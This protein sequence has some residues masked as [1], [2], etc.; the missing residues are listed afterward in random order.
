MEGWASGNKA[1]ELEKINGLTYKRQPFWDQAKL[2]AN[3]GFFASPSRGEAEA[4]CAY[5]ASY[6]VLDRR[7]QPS[8]PRLD[9]V[10]DR[11]YTNATVEI[12]RLPC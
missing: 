10:A 1:V 5:G 3:D 7:Y 4:L 11:I 2:K 12:Y 6:A 8:L 9:R